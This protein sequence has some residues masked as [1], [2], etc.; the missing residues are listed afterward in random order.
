MKTVT[1]LRASYSYA[2]AKLLECFD[3]AGEDGDE[4]YFGTDLGGR[5]VALPDP[6]ICNLRLAVCRVSYSCGASD[7]FY[8]FIDDEDELDDAEFQLVPQ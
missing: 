7:I 2:H 1:Q 5:L 6:R 3:G 8:Q 4:I